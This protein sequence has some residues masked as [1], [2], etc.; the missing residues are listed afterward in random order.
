MDSPHSKAALQAD[1]IKNPL[2]V[3]AFA[4]ATREA[5]IVRAAQD[6]QR[7]MR[8]WE[9]TSDRQFRV[10]ADHA[11]LRMESLIRERSSTQVARLE[12]ERGLQ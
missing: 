1:P 11:R 6:L 5:E 3:Q 4:D 8:A 12:L 2:V 10:M 9:E 7:H